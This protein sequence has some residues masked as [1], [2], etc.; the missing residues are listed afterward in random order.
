MSNDSDYKVWVGITYPFLN[1]HG[2]TFEV[3]EWFS[4]FIPYFTGH[5]IAVLK[6]NPR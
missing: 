1:V 3:C 4:K 6:V 2:E 5:V